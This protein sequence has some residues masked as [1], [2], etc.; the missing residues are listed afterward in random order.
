MTR[1]GKFRNGFSR[2]KKRH[3]ELRRYTVDKE[4]GVRSKSGC[5]NEFHAFNADFL[6][7]C[8]ANSISPGTSA[9]FEEVMISSC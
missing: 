3:A 4:V 6:E 7:H 2:G 5:V 1:A 9:I 8:R